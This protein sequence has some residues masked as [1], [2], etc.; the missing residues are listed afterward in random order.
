MKRRCRRHRPDR[1]RSN[2]FRAGRT[3]W[4]DHATILAMQRDA[5]DMDA[6]LPEAIF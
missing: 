6:L 1:N 2:P 5:P 3:T 4:S